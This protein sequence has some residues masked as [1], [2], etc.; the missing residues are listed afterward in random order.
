MRSGIYSSLH[1]IVEKRVLQS[2]SPLF[3]NPWLDRELRVIVKD[4]FGQFLRSEEEE[5]GDRLTIIGETGGQYTN[6]PSSHAHA[7]L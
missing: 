4:K 5:G 2:L 3:D 6:S 7:C 1:Q